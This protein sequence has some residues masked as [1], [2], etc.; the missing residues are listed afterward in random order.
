MRPIRRY[1]VHASWLAAALLA[2]LVCFWASWSYREVDWTIFRFMNALAIP[3][4][5]FAWTSLLV[6]PNSK[7]H[8][9]L[10]LTVPNLLILYVL[11]LMTEPDSVF[12][13]VP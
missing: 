13:T 10:A 3:S 9:V 6:S 12:R 1:W 5:L 2:C 11:A 4:L 8:A 7:V